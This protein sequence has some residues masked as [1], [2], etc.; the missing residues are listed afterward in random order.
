MRPALA[1]PG[2]P[3]LYVHHSQWVRS[4]ESQA[5]RRLEKEISQ[6]EVVN[7]RRLRA[8]ARPLPDNAK[9]R[10]GTPIPGHRVAIECFCCA[11]SRSRSHTAMLMQL[12]EHKM[13]KSNIASSAS[14]RPTFN[15]TSANLEITSSVPAENKNPT[16]ISFS[17]TT[18]HTSLN[19]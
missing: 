1:R 18:S 5:E 7:W 4:E 2:L 17:G 9:I 12:S 8:T 16:V 11:R 3:A 10:I 13:A 15:G 19:A 14:E 6:S